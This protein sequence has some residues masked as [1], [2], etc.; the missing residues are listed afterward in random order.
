MKLATFIPQKGAAPR[1]GVIRHNHRIVDLAET[2]A[3]LRQKAPFDCNDMISLI[4]S[5][6]PGLAFCHEMAGKAIQ[7]LPLDG[8]ELLAPIPLPRKNVFCVGWNYSEHFKEGEPIRGTVQE[9]PEHPTF[10][11]KAPTTVNSPCGD[12]ELDPKVTAKLDWEVE[13]AVV[14]GPGGK[15]IAEADAMKHVFGYTVANDVSARE[16]QRQHG[17]QWFKGK[18]I[19]GCCPM[20]PWIVTADE[21][22]PSDLHLICRLNGIVKQ[23]SY[24]RHMFFK[25]PRLI[26]ELSLGLTLEAGDLF[27]S[28]TPE[29]VGHARTPPEF[30][31]KGDVMETEISGI[32]LMRNRIV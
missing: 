16:I 32:G 26:A 25:L 11:S 5:G 15:N 24:T 31:Q 12:I 8:V 19:D 3:D 29:G 18:S 28:G 21:L 20:G 9:M 14:F 7:D 10:F 1:V 27:L 13:L 30:M 2:A 22:D 17:Q 4:A 6:K 23:D